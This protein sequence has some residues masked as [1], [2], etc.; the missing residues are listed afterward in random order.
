MLERSVTTRTLISSAL[1]FLTA[2]CGAGALP[3]RAPST[4]QALTGTAEWLEFEAP[5][6]RSEM[7]RDVARTSQTQA[8]QPATGQMVFPMMVDGEFVA[9]PG[10]DPRMDLLMSADAGGSIQLSFDG[11]ADRWSDDRRDSFQGLSEREAVELIARSLVQHWGVSR[12]NVIR[13]DRVAG[14]PYAAAYIDGILRVNPAFV[15]MATATSVP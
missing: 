13:V 14:A 15:Y 11:R 8:G 1:L 6:A 12:S 9:A 4:T 5:T 7:F 10:I 2:A 3:S